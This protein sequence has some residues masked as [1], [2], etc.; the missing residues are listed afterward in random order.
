MLGSLDLTVSPPG[1]PMRPSSARFICVFLG[2]LTAASQAAAATS[3]QPVADTGTQPSAIEAQSRAL[4]RASEAVVGVRTQAV[5]NARSAATLGRDRQGSGVLIGSDGLVLTIGYLVLEAEQVELTTHDG[6]QVPAR[7]VAYDLATGFGLV[8]AL[9]PLRLEPAPLGDSA[10]VRPREALLLA[11]GGVQGDI[12]MASL[13]S[14]R[15]FSAYW[16][17]HLDEALFTSPPRRDHAGAGLFNTQGELV[18]VGSL[19]V[20]DA[21]EPGAPAQ[22]GNMFVP[23]ALL[24]PVLP[25]LLAQGRS[26]ASLRAW[27]GLNCVEANGEVRIVRVSTDSPAD[28]AGLEA[29]DRILAIDGQAVSDLAVLWK[30]LWAKQPAARNVQLDIRRNGQPM[31]VTVYAVDRA[32][33]LR[34][35]EGV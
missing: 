14:R 11:S 26:S 25:E 18:G 34:R 13:A 4:Q 27:M 19:M 17:Y 20:A 35:A 3:S 33:T 12:G 7:V 5:A 1:K 15:A 31:R 30:T 23:I 16:E 32:W 21:A 28:V 8:R 6:R 10:T 24:A 9:A 2:V 29:G 22:A